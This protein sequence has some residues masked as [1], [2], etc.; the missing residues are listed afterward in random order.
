[1]E[2][3]SPFPSFLHAKRN[4]IFYF[5][6][7]FVLHLLPGEG[8][9]ACPAGLACSRPAVQCFSTTGTCLRPSSE[10][11]AGGHS[12]QPWPLKYRMHKLKGTGYQM[13][14]AFVNMYGYR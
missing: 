1:M 10:T 8:L 9:Q 13:G 11:A 3:V 2:R 5:T 7:I 6:I 12:A 14:M 4:S